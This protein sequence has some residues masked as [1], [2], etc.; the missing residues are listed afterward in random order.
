MLSVLG[1]N[2]SLVLLTESGKKGGIM[3]QL[4]LFKLRFT[5]SRNFIGDKNVFNCHVT[6]NKSCIATRTCA[7]RKRSEKLN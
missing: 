3:R 7:G 5:V 6:C 4:S 2:Y 1:C